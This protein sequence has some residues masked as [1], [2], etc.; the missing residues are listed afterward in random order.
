MNFGRLIILAIAVLTG[1]GVAKAQSPAGATG[2]CKD[3]TYSTA[4]SKNGAC[5]GHKGV[6]TWYAASNPPATPRSDTNSSAKS[7]SPHSNAGHIRWRSWSSLGEHRDQGLSL[8][9]RP[10]LRED[11]V[12]RLHE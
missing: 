4:T 1:C 3:G 5:S 8:Q 6:Q 7:S 2:Q 11:E 10:L 9:R 12:R